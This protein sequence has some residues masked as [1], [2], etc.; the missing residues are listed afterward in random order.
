MIAM[1]AI[2]LREGA[3]V[4]LVGGS[5][6]EE[7]VR[8]DDP[9]AVA[10]HWLRIGFRHLHIVDLDAATGRGSNAGLVSEIL[11][12]SGAT[13]QV[14]GGVRDAVDIERLIAA[15]AHRVVVGTRAIEDE[16][17][18]DEMTTNFPDRI[19]VAADVRER[20]VVTRGWTRVI[21]GDVI[22]TITR[23]NRYPVAGILVTAVHREG[24][25]EG[26]DLALMAEASRAATAPLQAS[27]GISTIDDLRA[28]A[29]HGAAAAVLGMSLYT[30]TID[31]ESIVREFSSINRATP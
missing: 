3:C 28:L 15:G 30:G 17:W 14:G 24:L 5:Y 18:L 16:E 20:Q 4:Q 13:A 26:A 10:R 27:G 25:M 8:L 22:E 6:D 12:L 11:A 23:L 2:D 31:S 7:R 1:P 9:V 19:I 29:E 21:P